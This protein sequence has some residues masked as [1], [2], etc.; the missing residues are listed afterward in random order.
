MGHHAEIVVVFAKKVDEGFGDGF[1][2]MGVVFCFHN[3]VDPGEN[4]L[5]TP[6]KGFH[7]QGLLVRE[8]A[9]DGGVG[10]AGFGCHMADVDLVE[11]F[12]GKNPFG[13]IND[14]LPLGIP[15]FFL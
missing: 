3:P 7:E 10:D 14:H 9:I 11:G 1:Q 8:I 2:D 15:F 6:Q 13:C 5:D 4:L 12:D